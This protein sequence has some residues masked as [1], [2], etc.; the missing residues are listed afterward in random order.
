M[1][2]IAERCEDRFKALVQEPHAN[3]LLSAHLALLGPEL[4]QLHTKP[5][6]AVR[7]STGID[8]DSEVEGEAHLGRFLPSEPEP[9]CCR[10]R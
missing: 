2:Y 6:L 5:P 10:D 8:S 4:Q 3:E 9:A 7:A 1:G